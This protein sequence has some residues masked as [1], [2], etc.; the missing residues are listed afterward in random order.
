MNCRSRGQ[1]RLVQASDY[2][3]FAKPWRQAPRAA[4][5]LCNI[6]L[7]AY[8]IFSNDMCWCWWFYCT[9]KVMFC[10]QYSILSVCMQSQTFVNDKTTFRSM[11]IDQQIARLPSHLVHVNVSLNISRIVMVFWLFTL[12]ENLSTC[13]SSGQ[14][15]H[16]IIWVLKRLLRV[17]WL[18]DTVGKVALGEFK[19]NS[20]K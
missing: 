3:T 6:V 18:L 14:S 4:V 12:N 13:L 20:G 5:G 7:P 10:I 1:I 9:P 11:I 15:T 8:W 19:F 17:I 2:E 16:Y